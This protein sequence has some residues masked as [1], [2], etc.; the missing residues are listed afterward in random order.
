MVCVFL[1]VI[2][3]SFSKYFVIFE[4]LFGENVVVFLRFFEWG[5]V[6]LNLKCFRLMVF[7]F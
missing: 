6:F 5:R 4:M 7:I 3:M 2:G 1:I